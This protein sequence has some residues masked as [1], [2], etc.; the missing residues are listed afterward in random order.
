M[1]FCYR[2]APATLAPTAVWRLLGI[3]AVGNVSAMDPTPL[4]GDVYV[5]LQLGG[6]L[7]GLRVVP[8]AYGDAQP[9][10]HVDWTALFDVAQL[11]SPDAFVQAA[12]QWWPEAGSDVREAR[13]GVYAG[14][15]VRVEAAARAG[16][17]IFF[18]VLPA[19]ITPPQA[20]WTTWSR[21]PT[22]PT[23][24][25]LLG[26]IILIVLAI[27]ARRNVR[28]GRG[29]RTGARRVALGAMLAQT[30]GNSLVA[31]PTMSVVFG[32]LPQALFLGLVTWLAYIGLEPP[33]RRTWP[34][35]L[36]AWTRLIDG[37]WR[38]PLV[39]RALLAGVLVGLPAS[40]P[41]TPVVTRLLGLPGSA[42]VVAPTDS[43]GG[44]GDFTGNL[45][46]CSATA[47]L[48]TL[49]VLGL[50]L[51][52]RLIG[53]R[54]DVAWVVF[55]L[56]FLTWYY[57]MV[58]AA[59]PNAVSSWPAVVE[60]GVCGL[61]FVWVLWKHGALATAIAWWVYFVAGWAPWTL[62]M[63]RWYA[64]RQWFVVAVVVAL[65]VW[66]FRNVLGRQSAFLT[67]A[68]DG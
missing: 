15:H 47:L 63:S 8:P 39:G 4:A 23:L 5:E 7:V 3:S 54:T 67:G 25:E 9:S 49:V 61:L 42:M 19:W 22:N 64:W 12:P 52:A 32:I 26:W 59:W 68:L 50:L 33:I 46:H 1:R 20:A 48:A 13:E 53:R 43:F 17:P 2:Q 44:P 56:I 16:R 37:R 36:I 11:G 34:Q 21:G 24:T 41:W 30:V 10:S 14:L 40:V 35:L 18:L 6:G 60:A 45:I 65:A 57:V 28:L 51:V 58:R 62:D 29:D 27:L 38:D 66:G 55:T 31:H